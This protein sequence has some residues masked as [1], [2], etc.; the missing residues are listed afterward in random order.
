MPERRAVAFS[1]GTDRPVPSLEAANLLAVP[2][3]IEVA[4]A[5]VLAQ[6]SPRPATVPWLQLQ[7]KHKLSLIEKLERVLPRQ[8]EHHCLKVTTRLAPDPLFTRLTHAL[9]VCVYV[10]V[11]RAA[12]WIRRGG[13]SLTLL[14][15]TPGQCPI[16]WPS[17]PR[18]ALE[19]LG[20]ASEG[21]FVGA[22]GQH[23]G[24]IAAP[25]PAGLAAADAPAPPQLLRRAHRAAQKHASSRGQARGESGDS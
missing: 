5:C 25:L 11:Y 23:R 20:V 17:S 2:R 16:L 8:L 24:R 22:Y 4:F 18:G 14:A 19:T 12:V 9:R 15:T 3:Q 6:T 7:H 13:D 10:C 1:Q 21:T